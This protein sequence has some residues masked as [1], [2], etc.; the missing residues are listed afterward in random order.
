MSK[1]RQDTRYIKRYRGMQSS[2]SSLR[3][4]VK[5]ALPIA[6][7]RWVARHRMRSGRANPPAADSLGLC[8]QRPRRLLPRN[9]GATVYRL[10]DETADQ[11]WLRGSFALPQ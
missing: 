1:L 6:A 7:M 4:A 3:A 5:S 2:E 10:D 11:G 9:K 8:P